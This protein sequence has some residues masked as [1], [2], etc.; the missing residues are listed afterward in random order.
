MRIEQHKNFLSLEE[1][2]AL[3][4]WVDL[5]VEN[6]WMGPAVTSENNDNYKRFTT[7]RYGGNFKY[8]ELVKDI[9]NRVRK[10]CGVSD[11]NIVDG[12]GQ[13]GII[14]SCTLEGGD[15]HPH[16]DGAYDGL[17]I[18]RCNII[19][20]KPI[21]GGKLY[22]GKKLVDVDAGELHCYLASEFEHY[23]TEVKGSVSRVL[24]MFGAY[25]PA[26]LWEN[27]TIQLETH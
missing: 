12:H 15:V 20:R 5:A 25:V 9:S 3:N 27:N 17:A 4:S 18:L 7:R 1:C 16:V 23:V 21:D 8:P 22:V 2:S 13:D 14:V 10:F 24:W 19:T 26:K 11:Y 6:N